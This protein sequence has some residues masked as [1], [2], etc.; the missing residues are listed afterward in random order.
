MLQGCKKHQFL[1]D[2]EGFSQAVRQYCG[3]GG[4]GDDGDADGDVGGGDDA[5]GGAQGLLNAAATHWGAW[6]LLLIPLVPSS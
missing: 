6:N 1:R 2:Y 4:G 5:G 3:D